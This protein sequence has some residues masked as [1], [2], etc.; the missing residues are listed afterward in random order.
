MRPQSAKS[1]RWLVVVFVFV[2]DDRSSSVV[3][4]VEMFEMFVC[5]TALHRLHR[6]ARGNMKLSGKLTSRI[7]TVQRTFFHSLALVRGCHTHTHTRAY[8]L[9]RSLAAC[10]HNAWKL[11]MRSWAVAPSE[12]LWSP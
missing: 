8:A 12:R 9:P 2:V 6:L 10:R 1:I 5:D 3:A 4:V 11:S 7:I